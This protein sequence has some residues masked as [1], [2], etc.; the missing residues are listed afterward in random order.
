MAHLRRVK[1]LEGVD[2][3]GVKGRTGG[4]LQTR[5]D[6][7]RAPSTANTRS[8]E[9]TAARKHTRAELTPAAKSHDADVNS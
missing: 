9:T 8:N 7:K 6:L 3:N 2:G 5:E 1:G 4:R